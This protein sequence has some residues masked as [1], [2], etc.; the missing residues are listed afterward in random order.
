MFSR[1]NYNVLFQ[2][3]KSSE[4]QKAVQMYLVD[5]LG[6]LLNFSDQK[7]ELLKSSE[8]YSSIYFD[9]N[10][11]LLKLILQQIMKKPN[12]ARKVVSHAF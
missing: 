12:L 9:K 11:E 8:V 1:A 2:F 4:L 5:N 6:E 7:L 3:L 10:R